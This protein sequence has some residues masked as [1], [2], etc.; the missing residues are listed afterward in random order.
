[1]NLKGIAKQVAEEILDAFK[2]GKLPNA[3]ANVFIHHKMDCPSES[4]SWRNRLL[5]AL[6]GHYDARGFRQWQKVGRSVTKGSRAFYILA[7][8]TVKAKEDD[9]DRGIQAGDTRVIGFRALPVF[10]YTQTEGEPLPGAAEETAFIEALPLI[11][12]ARSWDLTVS[13]FNGQGTGRLGSYRHGEGIAL[14]VENLATWAHELIH[15]ADDRAGTITRKTG[16]QLDNEVVAEFGGA[17]LLECLG[18]HVESD[19][20]GAYKYIKDYAEK[21]NRSPVSVCTELIDR[22]CACVALILET[23]G[24]ID[25]GQLLEEPEEDQPEEPELGRRFHLP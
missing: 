12:V 22:T 16:Q 6:H 1:M 8:M 7:P 5:T 14:G 10:G 19:R 18:H 17:I 13:T 21:H 4:W 9:E 15:A 11:N 20:G 24:T 23:A 3:L 25:D 2:A